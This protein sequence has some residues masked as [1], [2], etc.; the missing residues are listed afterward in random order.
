MCLGSFE[1]VHTCT[2]H[3]PVPTSLPRSPT[4]TMGSLAPIPPLARLPALS[5]LHTLLPVPVAPCGSGRVGGLSGTSVCMFW[6]CK[7]PLTQGCWLQKSKAL[8]RQWYSAIWVW[9]DGWE[10]GGIIQKDFWIGQ[11]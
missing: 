4:T 2:H 7:H 11:R 8:T 5:P 3:V 1:C 9:V 6:K 10:Q